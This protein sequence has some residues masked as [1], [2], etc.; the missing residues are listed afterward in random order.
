M[1]Y[2]RHVLAANQP[3]VRDEPHA[4]SLNDLAPRTGPSA[5]ELRNVTFAYNVNGEHEAVLRGV[6]LSI[7]PGESVA[8]VG[9]SGSGKSTLLKMI[10][11]M[12]D[13]TSG[14]VCVDGV[15]VRDVTLR[16]LRNR[17]AVVPQDTC[18]F[19]ASIEHNVR[20]G[21]E[22]ASAEE[23]EH[24]VDLSN[25]RGTIRKLADGM[26]TRVGERGNRLSGGERQKVSIAR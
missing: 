23:V 20:Y 1:G 3:A 5:V 8:L 16:S 13:P 7:P 22:Q 14:T 24:A 6:S 21:N 18:L 4:R 19:D 26:Q 9:S 2:M 17:I 10:T 11:R 25:L 15:D 12:L